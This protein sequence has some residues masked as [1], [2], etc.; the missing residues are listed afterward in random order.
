MGIITSLEPQKNPNRLSVFI[1]H[2]YAFGV[3]QFVAKKYKL[4]VGKSVK[5]EELKTILGAEELE[6]AKRYVVDYLLG[7]TTKQVQDKLTTKGYES[8]VIEQVMEFISQ[9]RLMDD[10]DYAKRYAHDAS[11]FKKHGTRKIKQTLKEKGIADEDV[12]LALSRINEQDEIDNAKKLLSNKI[13][14]YRK[15]AKNKYELKGK[16]YQFLASRGYTS[17]IIEHVLH[18]LLVDQEEDY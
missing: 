12:Q 13:N 9:Y 15:K 14:T 6:K 10:Q 17:D 1:D 5:P 18:Q 16:C 3:D 7:K 4:E 11:K 8:D 2:A